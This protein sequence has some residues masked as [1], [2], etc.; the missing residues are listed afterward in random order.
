MNAKEASKRIFSISNKNQHKIISILGLKLKFK[1]QNIKKDDI[2]I[3]FDK[4][5]KELKTTKNEI[6]LLRAIIEKSIDITKVPPAKGNL[7]KVQLIKTKVLDLVDVILK[8]HNIQYWLDFGTLIGAVR[9][10]GFVPWD[11][12]IDVSILRDD[13]L[14]L[15]QIFDK[16]L[17]YFNNPD[18]HFAYG[19]P[20]GSE[21]IRFYYKNF[22][23][24][25]F[26]YEF[27]NKRLNSQDEKE[28][29]I[30]KWAKVREKMLKKFP[31]DNFK[32]GTM[33]HLDIIEDVAKIKNEIFKNNYC[34]NKDSKQL[35]RMV[36]TMFLQKNC[37]VIE[38]DDIFPLQNLQF[39]N[40]LLP[41]PN[42][43]IESLHA[44]NMYGKKGS[45]M[46]FPKIPDSGFKHTQATYEDSKDDFDEIYNRLSEIVK[47][48]KTNN[49]N[50][51]LN[52]ERERVKN[53]LIS[54]KLCA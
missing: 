26:P 54:L 23:V 38:Y 3:K 50:Q 19:S 33:T 47:D 48:Y 18:L 34:I 22:C 9:H 30:K 27:I 43:P 12:D 2:K 37:G 44:H 28:E 45:I 40:L 14:K 46:T 49:Q 24:D 5:N 10:Q 16:E 8:K 1:K 41:A 31:L 52:F 53:A 20:K 51:V 15:P 25:F 17:S 32:N 4:L 11:N 6:K 7:R 13:Y 36:E 29:F 39:E 21:L 42:N 35:I